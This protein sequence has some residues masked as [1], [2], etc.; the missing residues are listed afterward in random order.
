VAGANGFIAAFVGGMTFGSIAHQGDKEG[1]RFTEEGGTLLSLLV[2]FAFGAV[3][4]VPGL[5]DASWRDVVFALLA[6]TILRMVPVGLALAGTGMDRATVA[7][8]GWFGPRGLASVVFG[9]IAVDALAPEASKAVLGAVTVTVAASVLLHGITAAPLA[10]RYGAHMARTHRRA[11]DGGP[12]P[13]ALAIRTLN[14][15]RRRSNVAGPQREGT[16]DD[17]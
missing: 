17:D 12:P 3:M 2:W 11:D 5:E 14:R 13:P 6:L 8:V 9:L 7:F 15:S 10:A 16:P 1:L 4:L